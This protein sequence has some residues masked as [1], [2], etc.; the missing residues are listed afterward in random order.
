M[1]S[2]VAAIFAKR[3][4]AAR[5]LRGLSQRALGGLVSDDKA[6]GSVRINRYE[7]SV[8]RADMDTAA[9]LARALDIPLAYLFAEEDDQAEMLLAFAQL[10]KGERSKL[11]SQARELV[12]KKAK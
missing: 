12:A 4:K 1:S 8:N 6:N 3:L 2:S 9:T 10:S 11:L 5:T 7:Q